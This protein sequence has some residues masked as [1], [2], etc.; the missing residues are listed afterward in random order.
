MPN[1]LDRPP[2]RTTV[3]LRPESFPMI[4]LDSIFVAP[5]EVGSREFPIPHQTQTCNVVAKASSDVALGIDFDRQHTSLQSVRELTRFRTASPQLQLRDEKVVV[6]YENRSDE[7][8]AL[9][10]MREIVSVF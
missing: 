5:R 6:V 7:P 2:F 1:N 9:A 8:V 4:E 10:V 3:V